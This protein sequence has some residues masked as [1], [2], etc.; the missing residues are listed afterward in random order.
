MSCVT[1]FDRTH[2]CWRRRQGKLISSHKHGA[3]CQTGHRYNIPRHKPIG[4]GW[5]KTKAT[6]L[7][8]TQW[9]GGDTPN[10]D[11]PSLLLAL[12]NTPEIVQEERCWPLTSRWPHPQGSAMGGRSSKARLKRKDANKG[13]GRQEDVRKQA[14]VTLGATTPPSVHGRCDA[15]R[16]FLA[17]VRLDSSMGLWRLPKP[18]GPVQECTLRESLFLPCSNDGHDVTT[19]RRLIV[20]DTMLSTLGEGTTQSTSAWVE[21]SSG[22]F[23]SDQKWS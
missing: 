8:H 13:R 17:V 9:R 19:K 5:L 12:P 7:G 21:K 2:C 23:A 6:P 15:T 10:G 11:L 4:Y 3:S 20:E 18:L 16:L 14:N 22:A 1:T